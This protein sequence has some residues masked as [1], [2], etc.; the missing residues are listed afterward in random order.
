MTY[1][2]NLG[3]GFLAY[4]E[5]LV[6]LAKLQVPVEHFDKS[7][8]SK[9]GYLVRIE[10]QDVKLRPSE[11]VLYGTDFHNA[12]HLR[13][14]TD[15]IYLSLAEDAVNISNVAALVDL[16][17]KPHFKYI[18]EGEKKRKVVLFK[19]SST[20]RGGMTSSSLEVLAGL[21]LLMEEYVDLM[22][23]DLPPPLLFPP[24]KPTTR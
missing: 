6:R 15:L 9:D 18:A 22:L 7:K 4:G 12:L 14:K 23:L 19:D 13:F 10:D 24:S 3:F 21:A 8:L 11:V 20:N 5:E 2:V 16:E 17:G 1:D